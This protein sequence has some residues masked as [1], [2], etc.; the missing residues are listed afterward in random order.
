MFVQV[1]MIW[2]DGVGPLNRLKHQKKF[3]W[4]ENEPE[5]KDCVQTSLIS[6]VTWAS[7]S[8]ESSTTMAQWKRHKSE[9]ICI[10]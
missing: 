5:I 2:V 1:G 7:G 6:F 4:K 10:K 8:L 9:C 3:A